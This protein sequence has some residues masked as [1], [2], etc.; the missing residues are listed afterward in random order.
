MA[1]SPV[2]DFDPII[3]S[4]LDDLGEWF[5]AG[6]LTRVSDGAVPAMAAGLKHWFE[7]CPLPAYTGRRLYPHGGSL[8][9]AGASVHHHYVQLSF[10]RGLWQQK[11]DEATADQQRAALD[12]L[13]EVFSALP[14]P[15][16]YTHSIP[17]YARVHREGLNGYRERIRLGL[18]AAAELR[19]AE[20]IE[21]Y[22]ALLEVLDGVEVLRQRCLDQIR[23]AKLTDAADEAR[24]EQ[25]LAALARVPFEPATTFYEAM[26]GENFLFFLDGCDDLGRFDQDLWPYYQATPLPDDEALALTRELWENVDTATAWNVAL[27]GTTPEGQYAYNHLTVLA[28][29][30]GK[31]RRRPNLALRL[32]PDA[33]EEVWDEALE[34]ISGGSGIPAL[35]NEQ[36]YLKALADA[37]L[38][39]SVPDLRNYAF[40]GCTETMIHGRSNVGSLDAG[41]NLPEVLVRVLPK[42]PEHADFESFCGAVLDEF[43][44][45]IE[46]LTRHVSHNQETRAKT[47]PQ[48][49]RTLLIDDCIDHGREYAAGG[50]RW[51]WSVINVEGLGNVVDS[52]SVIRE[53]VYER[54]EVTATELCAALAADWEGYETLR[55]RAQRCPK[56][57]N[58]LPETDALAQRVSEH[59]FGEL[60]SRAPWRGGRFLPACLMFVTYAQAGQ[61]VPATPDGRHA[62]TPIAD[63]AGAVQGRDQS[64][65]TAALAS[66][67]AL[68]TR[69]APGTLVVNIRLSKKLFEQR[70]KV[71]ALVRGYF[72]MGGLQVQI[73]VVDQA[74][75]RDALEHPE[76]HGDLIIRMGG[77]S[78]YW[79]RLS[80][81]LQESV[82]ERIEHE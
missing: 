37:H 57:G 46:G 64:G 38:N 15:G 67:A 79:N 78:E 74:L 12:Q 80:R 27:G 22:E 72:A 28:I 33:P 43:T 50:A 36:A 25:L 76:Q 44:T 1:S 47:H 4:V 24:R 7:H 26:V 58:G 68:E 48:L 56:Y 18:Q 52:L 69:L 31:G 65:P 55:Q 30:A 39:L 11:R 3:T 49:L 71:K 10:N 17:H 21:L 61:R 8:Y 32:H 59:V 13:N 77:Y 66:A 40:G 63:S 73:N 29:R 35:Y 41:I 14:Y 62:G 9:H 6:Y 16:G 34:T 60:M 20:R 53:L 2:T 70:E 81:A 75:L 23:S 42:L 5:A 51:N 54:G 45:A 82:L 19:D